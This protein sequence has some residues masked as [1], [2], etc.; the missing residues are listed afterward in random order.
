MIPTTWLRWTQ[1]F[2]TMRPGD[3]SCEVATLAREFIAH[4]LAVEVEP[5]PRGGRATRPQDRIAALDVSE[6]GS[7]RE[8]AASAVVARR[9]GRLRAEV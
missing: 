8:R 4:G 6:I 9:A 1:P 7:P 3:L 2:D 5:P